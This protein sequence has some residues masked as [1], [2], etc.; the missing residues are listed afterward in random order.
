MS[1]DAASQRRTHVFL[2]SR[3]AAIHGS[4]RPDLLAR[5]AA[6]DLPL[7]STAPDFL[8]ALLHDLLRRLDTETTQYVRVS[9]GGEG[10]G[11]CAHIL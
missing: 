3:Y 11:R 9:V 2:N 10:S 1:F 4:S 6:H 5:F 8:A 7:P